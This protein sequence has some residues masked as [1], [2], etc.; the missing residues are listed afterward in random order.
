MDDR[1]LVVTAGALDALGDD[2]RAQLAGALDAAGLGL[3]LDVGGSRLFLSPTTEHFA[4]PG[5]G[6]VIGRM[7]DHRGARIARL[8]PPPA[9]A[10]DVTR[11][12]WGGYVLVLAEG[13]RGLTVLRDPSG[14]VQCVHAIDAGGGFVTSDIGIAVACGLYRREV[15]WSA[16]LAT[17]A[18][19][20]LRGRRTCLARVEELLP[21]CRLTVDEA[22][23]QACEW[24]PWAFV[25][26]PLRH[27]DPAEAQGCLREAVSTAVRAMCADE[28][29]FVLE[30]SGG[31]DSSIV[32]TS[33]GSHAGR[34]H[35]CTLRLPVSG[36][37]ESPYARAVADSLGRG[38]TCVDV[39]FEHATFDFPVES[40]A[41]VPGVGI[42]QNA[43]NKTWEGVAADLGVSRFVTGG[44]GDTVFCYLRTA[45][46]VVDAYRERGLRAALSV[47]ADLGE[48][49][50]CST[51]KVG[52]LAL[53][54]RRRRPDAGWRAERAFLAGERIPAQ[55]PSHPW[56]QSPAAPLHGDCERIRELVGNLVFRDLTPRGRGSRLHYPLL[57]QPVMEACLRVPT[58]MWVSRGRDR[59]VARDAFADRLPA[60]VLNRRGKGSYDTYM[61]TVYARGRSGMREFLGDGVLRAHGLL[62]H[63]AVSAHLD[64][65]PTRDLSFLRVFELCA[66]EN[67][68]RRQA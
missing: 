44:G 33:L 43:V 4:I 64:A 36:T 66:A 15:D 39:G 37:D 22:V 47:A 24:S 1:Y 7:F 28:R 21:G 29:A 67:W 13:D 55:A 58:W 20:Q 65:E 62:D 16:L 18:F 49:H 38:L 9:R 17:L 61:A 46:P 59:A 2:G 31:L 42:L 25:A 12:A 56:L 54:K 27:G 14:A 3:G 51:W 10:A 35:F 60:A 53:K 6:V 50:G 32:A 52:R 48:L 41:V 5:R 30:L 8:E 11:R 26:A 63:A 34:A 19:P 40:S 23:E 68:A 57:S 45:A